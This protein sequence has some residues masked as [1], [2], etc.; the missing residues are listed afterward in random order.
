MSDVPLL[1]RVDEARGLLG[2]I[3]SRKFYELLNSGRLKAVKLDGSTFVHAD[4]IRRFTETLPA[5]QPS[6]AV[7]A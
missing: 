1:H 3:G 5:Y 4:E 6:N 7:A 2:G